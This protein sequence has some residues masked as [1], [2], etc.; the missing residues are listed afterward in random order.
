[1]EIFEIFYSILTT[2]TSVR[3]QYLYF[4]N[5]CANFL[6]ESDI[7]HES[8]KSKSPLCHEKFED[9]IF[10]DTNNIIQNNHQNYDANQER[11]MTPSDSVES[12]S[13]LINEFY[14]FDEFQDNRGTRGFGYSRESSPMQQEYEFLEYDADLF[15]H[16]INPNTITKV[17]LGQ[18]V[19]QQD[20]G[21]TF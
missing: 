15:T 6:I 16:I 21:I 11:Y 14:I 9:I 13:N 19:S 7:D 3:N 12:L 10:V 2:L 18:V 1:M 17:I 8:T 4:N 5:T 20:E